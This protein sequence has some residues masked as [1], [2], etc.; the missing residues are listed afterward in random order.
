MEFFGIVP[1]DGLFQ[2]WTQ[3]RAMPRTVTLS[4]ELLQTFVALIRSDGDAARA[5]RALGINQ[6]TMS[7]R[8]R[9]VQHAGPL[10]EQPWVVRR[11]KTWELT[12]EGRRV[13]SA[14]TEIVDRYAN[15]ERFL[16]GE[17]APAQ[18]PIRFACGQQM[19]MGLVRQA[20]RAFRKDHPGA[21]IRISTLRGQARIEG[22]SNGSLDLAVVTHDEST[23]HEIARRPL[24]IEPLVEHRL[25]LV[26]AA[27]SPWSRA[28]R[29]LPKAGVLAAALV[30]FPLILPEPDAGV[31][32]G[33]D[34]VLHRQ[35]V[36][37]RLTIALEI[38]GWAAILAYVRDRFGVG[39]V[40]VGALVEAK[41]LIVR[42]LDPAEFPSIQ[43][44]LI[45]RRLAGSGPELDL[46]EPAQEWRAVLRQVA[47]RQG[48][49]Q[50]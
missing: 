22:V 3:D 7:K 10:L 19:V 13:W 16:D 42:T 45:C 1:R 39:I 35:G 25:A 47:A 24:H 46:S 36:M 11:G 14:V 44:R 5:M 32:R 38:G 43:A 40:S 20:L 23:I 15:L 8:L 4:F 26:C 41:G 21:S 27:D 37:G 6:P 49:P 31:R 2:A 12:E 30:D 29:R 33:L 48:G 34:E 50:V 9:Y 28:V 18:A 17:Q